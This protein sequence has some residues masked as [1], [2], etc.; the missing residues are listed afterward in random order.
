MKLVLLTILLIKVDSYIIRS[1]FCKENVRGMTQFSKDQ[2]LGAWY[3]Y[4]NTFEVY[5]IGGT[6]VRATYTDEG[7]Q[8]GVFN[9]Q[10]NSMLVYQYLIEYYSYFL[11]PDATEISKDLP[12]LQTLMTRMR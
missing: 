10:V 8:I 11:A 12:G 4:A 7:D 6:C 3:E 2:Y 1:G 9:E 5:E